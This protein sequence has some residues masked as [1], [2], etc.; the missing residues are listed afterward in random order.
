MKRMS[1]REDV[2]KRMSLRE[3]VV[4][5]MSQGEDKGKTTG[6]MSLKSMYVGI[7]TDYEKSAFLNLRMMWNT[8]H[9][10]NKLS[11]NN[12]SP[13]ET[14]NMHNSLSSST[15]TTLC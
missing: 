2:M 5:R 3:G 7:L 13:L 9:R 12:V 14:H 1:L 6:E 8:Y 10:A 4:K 15:I 11:F